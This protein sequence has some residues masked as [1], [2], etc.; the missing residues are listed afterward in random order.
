MRKRIFLSVTGVTLISLCIFSFFIAYVMYNQVFESEKANLKMQFPQVKNILLAQE[1]DYNFSQVISSIRIS[2]IS[3]DGTVLFDNRKDYK[4]ME[5]HADRK[6]VIALSE[7][8]SAESVR[9]S[10]TLGQQTY[11]YAEKLNDTIIL[12]L[13]ITMD[14]IYAII[15]NIVPFMIV[16][17]AIILI[18][19]AF[20]SRFLTQR[21]VAPLYNIDEPLYDEL[22]L[23]YQKIRAQ[24]RYIRKQ[25]RKLNQKK[26]EFKILTENIGDGLIL[27]DKNNT[28]A[29]INKKAAHIFELQKNKLIGKNSLELSRSDNFI[30]ALDNAYKGKNSEISLSIHNKE[31]SLHI[32]PVKNDKKNIE[33]VVGVVIIAIDYTEKA[34]AERVRK[35]FSANVSH[36]LKTPLTSILG[37]A[38]LVKTGMA[39]QEDVQGFC[40]KIHAEATSLLELIDDILKISRLDEIKQNFEKES[41]NLK[42]LLENIVSRLEIIAEK[43]QITLNTNL[44]AISMIGIRSI[45]DETFYN[46]IE[47]AIKYN[48]E[49]GE[50]T[51]NLSKKKSK[52]SVCVTDTGI[53][54]P[55]DSMERIF[56]RFYRVDKSHSSNIKGTGLGLS[57]VKHAVSLHDGKI[58]VKSELLK[59]TEFCVTFKNNETD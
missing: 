50:V 48:V 35:E 27:L 51:I 40:E 59:G 32:A 46:I 47:N 16:L 31:Y 55:K 9:L 17:T 39:K 57:I 25:K 54:I 26:E 53:G 23:F 58:S 12:R 36:E 34:Q 1:G 6:E 30:N 21:I 5:N 56:E 33:R 49:K 38:E 44:D 52:I 18:V 37:Y 13:S 24:D 22:D 8:K 45:L 42:E 3:D 29:S 43:K 10:D 4:S 41:V 15:A 11:Y 20:I 19:A 7:N 14:S 2:I 28:I